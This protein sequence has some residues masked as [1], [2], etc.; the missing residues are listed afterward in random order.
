MKKRLFVFGCSLTAYTYP[1]WA[2]IISI[3]YDEYYN[4]GRTGGS[5]TLIMNRLIEVNEKFKFNPETDTVIIMISGIGRFSYVDPNSN[6]W[7][8]NGEI[9]S[10]AYSTNKKHLI[11]FVENMWSEDGAVYMSWVAIK[12]IK[13]ILTT[14]S[15]PHTILMG[16]S[17]DS[18]LKPNEFLK[19]TSV[20]LTKEILELI[21]TKQPLQDW[22]NHENYKLKNPNDGTVTWK[23]NNNPDG[24]PSPEMHYKF[25]KTFHPEWTNDKTDSMLKYFQ[26]NLDYESPEI[27]STLFNNIFR[28]ERDGAILNK[29]FGD[30]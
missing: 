7:Q 14:L 21:D 10:N 20:T 23:V 5:N 13:F 6:Y 12:T 29:L 2:D 3:N 16:I 4:Y 25:I 26:S 24:H 15:I 17:F 28:K 27:C 30:N 22:T 11:N 9:K 1:T 19:E 18:Y 8:C